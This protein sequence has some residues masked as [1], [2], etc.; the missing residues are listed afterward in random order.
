MA[1]VG[2]A[3]G[4]GAAL[5]A[6]A[7]S[8]W[9]TPQSASAFDATF[10]HAAT[11]HSVAADSETDPTRTQGNSAISSVI[12]ASAAEG[13]QVRHGRGHAGSKAANPESAG[14]EP[15]GHH[16]GDHRDH[17]SPLRRMHA[18]A[19][20]ASALRFS[21]PLNVS[22][23]CHPAGM[24]DPSHRRIALVDSATA[25]ALAQTLPV[26]LLTLLVELRRTHL[27]RMLSRFGLGVLFF[28]FGL[29]ETILVLS[30]DGAVYPLQWFDLVSALVIFVL[31]TVIFLL[32]LRDP[33]PKRGI[34]GATEH[35]ID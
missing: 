28:V 11:A 19:G 32:S 3:L 20:A 6:G 8:A 26:L 33:P 9:A 13:R 25:S 18:A 5:T 1:A 35:H 16:A 14:W 30:I 12:A 21:A 10:A 27:H 7:G 31:L 24:V 29:I 23:C 2:V 15:P 22:C 4:I 17:V 34:E